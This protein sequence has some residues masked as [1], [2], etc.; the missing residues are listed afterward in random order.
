METSS[1]NEITGAAECAEVL[2]CTEAQIEEDARNGDLPGFKVSRGWRFVRRDLIEFLAKRG[3]S[4]AAERQAKRKASTPV[5]LSGAVAPNAKR[6][7]R[8]I[9]PVLPQ[10]P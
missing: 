1:F 6:S 9:P 5:M 2:A 7:R 4:K 8:S 10:V 3:H